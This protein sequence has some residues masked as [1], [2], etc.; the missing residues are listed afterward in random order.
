MA[1]ANAA[2]LDVAIRTG[3]GLLPVFLV[4]LTKWLLGIAI[5]QQPPS[6]MEV[7]SV[8]G[9]RVETNSEAE[10]LISLAF[11]FEPT[12]VPAEDPLGLANLPAL[13]PDECELSAK[14]LKQIAKRKDADAI[15]KENQ[16]LYEEMVTA[17]AGLLELAR[18]DVIAFR[19]WLQA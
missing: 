7:K 12:F 18:Y 4:G 13:Q 5:N 3:G 8:I 2:A 16:N 14:A 6:K 17:T 11:R 1:I 15:L 19:A 9:Y 10:D